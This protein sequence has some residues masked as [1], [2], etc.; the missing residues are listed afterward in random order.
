[1]KNEEIFPG[2]INKLPEA[3]LPTPG[4]H[5]HLLQ[6]EDQQLIFMCFDQAVEVGEH[7]HEAQWGAVLDGQIEMTIAGVTRL[8][9]KGDTYYIPQGVVHQARISQGYKQIVFFDQPDRYPVKAR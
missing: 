4:C 1:M 2:I 8:Y 5:G 6:G 9:A 7:A 3:D